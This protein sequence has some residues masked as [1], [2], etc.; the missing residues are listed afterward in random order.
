MRRWFLQL[1]KGS[2]SDLLQHDA[3]GDGE[4]P[5]VIVLAVDI[6]L[7]RWSGAAHLV[8]PHGS[9]PAPQLNGGL[10]RAVACARQWH[11]ELLSGK[12]KSQPR[13]AN[14]LGVSER[15]LRKIIPCAFLAPDIVEA[16][17]RGRQPADL[18]L[19]KLT[20]GLP[21]KWADQRRHLAFVGT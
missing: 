9:A 6:A 5:P 19:A 16:I 10:I 1:L 18:T 12:G 17:L 7:R 11:A 21:N 20:H 2:E 4:N 14:D 8:V 15:Y 3:D 13:I